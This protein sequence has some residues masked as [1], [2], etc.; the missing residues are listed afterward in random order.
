MSANRN[1]NELSNPVRMSDSMAM[2][3]RAVRRAKGDRSWR[4]WKIAMAR[5]L[6]RLA[7]QANRMKLLSLKVAGDFAAIYSVEMPVPRRPANGKLVVGEKA[8]FHLTYFEKYRWE[9]PPP[10]ALLGLVEPAD[11]WHPN[12]AV[13]YRGAICLGAQQP[14]VA[15]REIVLQGYSAV[16]LQ[17]VQLDESDPAGVLNGEA[18]EFYRGHPEYVPLTRVGFLDKWDGWKGV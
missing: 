14:G 16:C 8:V 18:C 12:S 15:P 1:T 11:M 2:A 17:S 13:R 4:E 3:E 5:D 10:W 6:G 7:E 9:A